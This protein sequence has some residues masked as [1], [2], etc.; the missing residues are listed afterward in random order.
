MFSPRGINAILLSRKNISHLAM[1]SQPT[2]KIANTEIE[3]QN[4]RIYS[5]WTSWN[6]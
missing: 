5:T 2:S 1:L 6:L 3:M 4:L